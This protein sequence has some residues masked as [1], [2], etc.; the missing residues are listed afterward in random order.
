[1]GTNNTTSVATSV[2]QDCIQNQKFYLLVVMYKIS[3]LSLIFLMFRDYILKTG[4]VNMSCIA[5]VLEVNGGFINQLLAEI[6]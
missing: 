2:N 5:F 4:A 6:A 1:M 3:C